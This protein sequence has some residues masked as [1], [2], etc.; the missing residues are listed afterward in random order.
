MDILQFQGEH[1]WLSN[2]WPCK[3]VFEG[4]VY[5]SIEAAYVAAKTTDLSIRERIRS[6]ESIGKIKAL[7]RTFR[8]RD[9]WEEIKCEVMWDLLQ[10]KFAPESELG[11]RLLETGDCRIVEG[12]HWGDTFWGVCNGVGE[13]HLGEAIMAMRDLLR[14]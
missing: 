14:K 12:N 7:G 4:D 6:M 5:N 11:K 1:R 8:L 9:N 13:N 2:F 3:V 10:Q